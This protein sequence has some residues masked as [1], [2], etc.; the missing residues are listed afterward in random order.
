MMNP[1]PCKFTTMPGNDSG[2]CRRHPRNQ[3]GLFILTQHLFQGFYAVGV[4]DSIPLHCLIKDSREK[5]SPRCRNFNPGNISYR[6]TQFCIL[7]LPPIFEVWIPVV[8]F[9]HKWNKSYRPYRTYKETSETDG[10]ER[11]HWFYSFF[12]GQGCKSTTFLQPGFEMR[13][14]LHGNGTE[15]TEKAFNVSSGNKT[16]RISAGRSVCLYKSAALAAA[17]TNETGDW[18]TNGLKLIVCAGECCLFFPV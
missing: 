17:E 6:R 4:I 12:L 5:R 16:N 13:F 11:D 2:C 8:L 15:D 3:N 7:K 9:P 18:K 10:K 14:G 1:F